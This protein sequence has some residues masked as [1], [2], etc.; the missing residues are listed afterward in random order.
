MYWI[1]A[2]LCALIAVIAIVVGRDRWLRPGA[3]V[4][5]FAKPVTN[6]TV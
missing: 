4:T 1:L 2:A 3:V 5:P 6:D